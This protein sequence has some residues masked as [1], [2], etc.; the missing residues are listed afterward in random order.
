MKKRNVL[1]LVTSVDVLNTLSGGVSEP[2]ISFTEQDQGREIRLHV[3]GINKEMMHVEVHNNNLSIY[4]YLNITSG[5]KL[6]QI[7]QIVYSRVVPY[8]IDISK[9]NA[10]YEEDELVVRL[11]FNK[12]ANGY[13]KK[14]RIDEN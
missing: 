2:Q 10:S 12:L 13:H 7:P 8:F 4:Y 3:P 6:I 1:D 11:P 5:D 9:I 14:I